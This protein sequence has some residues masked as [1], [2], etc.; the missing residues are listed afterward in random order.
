MATPVPRRLVPLIVAL[1]LATAGCGSDE[2]GRATPATTSAHTSTDTDP[3]P[4]S[5]G[6]DGPA[7]ESPAAD[8]DGIEIVADI[9]AAH[10]G[11]DQRVA[12][13][14][15]PPLG[16][17][18]DAVWAA[19]NGVVYPVAVR[20]ENMVH[21]LEHGAVW[22]TYDPA[23]IGGADLAALQAVVTG[24]PYLMLSPYPGLDHP[25]SLQSWGHQLKLDH[26][27]DP[28]IAEFV[29]TL[30]ANPA[31]HPE[32]GATCDQ[33]PAAFDPA[34]PPPF[35]PTPPGPDAVAQG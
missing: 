35:D 21:S 24:Q 1:A 16:G 19:C 9:G 14:H 22:I 12:Y 13:E 29:T 23:R 25:I 11:A 17:A 2:A 3:D 27:A 20:N 26:P 28:R 18:H 4:T 7:Q 33:S 31:T 5:E 8:I 6:S 30:R 10:V 32:P 15:L 34:N